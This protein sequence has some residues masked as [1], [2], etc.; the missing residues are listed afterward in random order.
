MLELF[1]LSLLLSRL[2]LLSSCEMVHEG[3]IA[4]FPL[5]RLISMHLVVCRGHT[6]TLCEVELISGFLSVGGN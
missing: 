5:A 3:D 4:S 1:L 2:L 6:L